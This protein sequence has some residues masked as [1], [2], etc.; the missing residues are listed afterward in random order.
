GAVR[1]QGDASEERGE[2]GIVGG[3]AVGGRGVGWR[4]MRS[5]IGVAGWMGLQEVEGQVLRQGRGML[6]M[7]EQLGFTISPDPDEPGLMLVRLPVPAPGAEAGDGPGDA[8]A[9]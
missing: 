3:S 4:L 9:A 5:M 7:C 6:A 2:D 8:P 1:R